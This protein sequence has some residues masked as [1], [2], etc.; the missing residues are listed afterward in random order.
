M[1]KPIY[2]DS[3]KLHVSPSTDYF[4]SNSVAIIFV[5]YKSTKNTKKSCNLVQWVIWCGHLAVKSR[6]HASVH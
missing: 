6:V 3:L 1:K 5:C 2:F 4:H